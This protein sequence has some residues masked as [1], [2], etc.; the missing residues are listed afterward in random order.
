MSLAISAVDR[1]FANAR[2][3]IAIENTAQRAGRKHIARHPDNGICRNG[4]RIELF[5]SVLNGSF[6]DIADGEPGASLAK[7]PAQ[8]VAD[9]SQAAQ[10]WSQPRAVDS[11]DGT[12]ASGW[13]QL[14]VYFAEAVALESL[15]QLLPGVGNMLRSHGRIL[16]LI[17]V[18]PACSRGHSVGAGKLAQLAIVPAARCAIRR[19]IQSLLRLWLV[20]KALN[21]AGTATNVKTR[22]R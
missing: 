6:V 17:S 18:R 2:S 20:S 7:L 16:C 22:S 14:D 1:F 13:V 5:D 11:D 19:R 15:Q 10:G 8:V 4:L 9:V 21:A 3:K 12:Q